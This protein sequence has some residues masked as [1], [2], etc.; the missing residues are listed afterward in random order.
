MSDTQFTLFVGSTW[1]NFDDYLGPYPDERTAMAAS[2]EIANA[3]LEWIREPEDVAVTAYTR[4]WMYRVYP[5]P[6]HDESA[7]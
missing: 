6:E 2:E 1:D 5:T 7:R 4:G 3:P